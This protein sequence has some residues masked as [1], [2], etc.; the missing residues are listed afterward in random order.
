MKRPSSETVTADGVMVTGVNTR[1]T[2]LFQDGDKL[3]F[4]GKSE[5]LKV[6]NGRSVGRNRANGTHHRGFAAPAQQASFCDSHALCMME[7]FCQAL[8]ASPHFSGT[9]RNPDLVL[10]WLTDSSAQFLALV[11]CSSDCGDSERYVN[12]AGVP[13]TGRL[14][15]GDFIVSF[16]GFAQ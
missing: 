11:Y 9:V 2:E 4:R 3:R 10:C 16:L 5:Q 8:R 15:G 6:R 7:R 1:F 13:C 12:A 14:R